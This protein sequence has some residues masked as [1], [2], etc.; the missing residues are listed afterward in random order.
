M[1]KTVHRKAPGFRVLLTLFLLLMASHA[2]AQ[3]TIKGRVVAND[4]SA[5]PGVTVRVEGTTVGTS[6]G[7]D[8]E[9]QL[10]VPGSKSVLAFS[11]VGYAP[12]TVAVGSQTSINVTLVDDAKALDEVVVVGYGTQ[13]Q[14][15]VTGSIVSV[16]AEKIKERQP[17][18]VLDALQGQASGV[19]INTESQPGGGASIRIRG[20]G[21]FLGG[22]DPLYV[23]DGVPMENI[24]GIN[25]NDVQSME[26]LKDAASTAIYGSRSANGVIIITTKKGV[27]GKPQL[28][29]TY[30]HVLGQLAHKLPQAT[31][32]DRRLYDLKMKGSL[33]T[34]SLSADSL[35][36][37]QN[38]DN[39]L[40]KM[41]TRTS[42]RDQVD[43]TV[44]GATDKLNYYTS[45]GFLNDQ[46]II[47]NS[48][49]RIARARI[50]VDYKA[51]ERFTYGNR[52][53]FSYEAGN[54]IDEGNTLRQAMQRP[55]TFRIY[56]P[57]GSFAGNLGGRH[58]PV[59]EALLYKN[60][61]TAYEGSVYN[62]LS[63]KILD[64]LKLTS[65][66]NVR[67][68]YSENTSFSPKILSNDGTQNSGSYS[69]GLNLYW[70]Q[71]NYFNYDKVFAQ[72]HTVNAV[73]GMSTE[74]WNDQ[75]TRLNGSSYVS[76]DILTSNAMGI[77]DLTRTDNTATRHTM[78]GMFARFGYSFKGKYIFNAN[79]R[80]DG[81]SRFGS[82]NRWGLF[83]SA[84][85]GWRFSDEGFMSW[86]QRYLQDGKLRLSYG[87]T[88]NERI[89]NYSSQGLY[90]FGSNYYN[91]ISGIVP[92]NQL[93]NDRLSWET[94]KQLDAGIDLTFLDNRISFTADYYQKETSNLLYNAPLPSEIGFTTT[95]V[96]VGSVQNKGFEFSI[97]AF[98][99]RTATVK[100]NV[101]YN[102]S[103]N[104]N[105]V[106]SLYGG[107]AFIQSNM[108]YIREGGQLGDFFGYKNLGVYAYDQSNAYTPDGTRLTPN[109]NE[110]GTF[111][112]YSL[113]G[114]TY[115]GTVKQL[116]TTGGVSKGGDVI[117][118]DT[119]GDGLID[120]KDRVVL[121]NAQPK[122]TAGL[123][124]QVSYKQFS[125]SFNLY[126]QWGNTIYNKGR[127]D[128]ST[129]NGTNLTPDRYIIQQA[130][131]KPGD[132]TNVPKVP[133]ASTMMNM[134]E[135]NSYFLE[136]GSF[137]RLRNVRLTYDLNPAVANYL[138]LKALSVYVY[139]NNLVTWT[140]YLWFDPELNLGSP[141]TMGLDAGVYPRSRQV[142]AGLNLSF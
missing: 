72:N 131:T 102:M 104:R 129:F 9:Y 55:P 24:N 66:F 32:N 28:N 62:Y 42:N 16:N 47:I 128:Q 18:T 77:R 69:N 92:S 85:V 14:R 23:V 86:A 36:P 56:L 87:A 125:L 70:L 43:L 68:R 41:L 29:V 133:G 82:S 115:T 140:N 107:T 50:N 126:T 119:N 116:K 34:I 22:S 76:E 142:G 31:A 75:N 118:Q 71:T 80:R 124:N 96:N 105:S 120:D 88:G 59:A 1:I 101:G 64:G 40:Q 25:P 78:V 106:N 122:F 137:I 7:P 12:K 11:F 100:W 60:Y 3:Q 136:N 21:T 53:Q 130:W 113:D 26:V 13:K 73:L 111:V 103:F 15:D 110:Q 123:Y 35:N 52:M 49:D 117:W 79:V 135:L 44:S 58:N 27:L 121:G 8:G 48:Y 94:T 39:D 127:Y 33:G 84:S 99:V 4:G 112:N 37:S 134:P 141:L 63:F 67:L 138:K 19:Q 61:N 89:G 132:I 51:T 74:Y 5:L 90:T 38:A 20:T 65:D 108:W 17:V 30:N 46:G 57:D 2:W 54:S 83:P 10:S 95:T 81:S 139:G 45:L 93:G 114:Q 97:N 6:T 98:P 91:G 109:F